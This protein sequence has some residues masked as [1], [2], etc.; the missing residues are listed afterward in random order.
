[1]LRSEFLGLMLL[2]VRIQ[3]IAAQ[4]HDGGQIKHILFVLID[5]LG[6]AVRWM[7]AAWV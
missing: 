7:L 4:P 6:Y 3:H 5:D 2:L 1:M